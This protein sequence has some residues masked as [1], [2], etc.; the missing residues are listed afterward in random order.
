M[1]ADVLPGPSLAELARTAVAG[2]DVAT[3]TCRSG[4][5][6]VSET[7]CIRAGLAGQPVVL[8]A[9]GSAMT[10]LIGKSP[11]VTVT[12]P[13]PPPFRGLAVTGVAR[14]GSAQRA[15][16]RFACRVVPRSLHFTGPGRVPVPLGEYLAAAPDPL[17]PVAARIVRHLER[18]HM[19]DLLTCV[20]AHG[21][22]RAEWV[23]P[24]RLD[25]FGLLLA[26]FTTAGIAEVRLSFPDGPVASFDEVPASLRSVLACRCHESDH[27]RAG[28]SWA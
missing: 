4:E 1:D 26:V 14:P 24:R 19:A 9:G 15:G 11:A 21:M 20:R 27:D 5:G 6:K 10:R 12:V 16:A 2:A 22:D 23:V 25:R 17:W 18:G 28:D 7:A 13:A 8:L 3:V